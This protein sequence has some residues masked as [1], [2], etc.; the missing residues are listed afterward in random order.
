MIPK[1]RVVSADQVVET[2]VQ[3]LGQDEDTSRV[4]RP[5]NDKERLERLIR[6]SDM[7]LTPLEARL[8]RGVSLSAEEQR[9]MVTHQTTIMKLQM[10][11]AALEAKKELG[12]KSNV[13]LAEDMVRRGMEKQHVLAY[14]N[15]SR[16][17]QN[18]I[19]ESLD[20][21]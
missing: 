12:K 17:V 15:N 18:A 2:R 11:L 8:E 16:E 5:V 9:L 14:F 21:D 19:G 6:L 1:R 10:S 13:E 20:D 3:V 7:V 4:R